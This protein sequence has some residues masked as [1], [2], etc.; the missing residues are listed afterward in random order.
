MCVC[1]CVCVCACVCTPPARSLSKWSHRRID[2]LVDDECYHSYANPHTT[3]DE[4]P[5]DQPFH[6]LLNVTVGGTWGGQQG[7]DDAVFPCALEVRYVRVFEREGDED[8]GLH[9][10]DDGETTTGG[11]DDD[12]GEDAEEEGGGA[13]AEENMELDDG[14]QEPE[15]E[16]QAW[17]STGVSFDG[18]LR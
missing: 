11:D 6:L 14:E 9:D 3:S 4:W 8:E 12:D 13:A 10:S 15:R 17:W 2:I 1:V 16:S 18:W 5:F 7:V